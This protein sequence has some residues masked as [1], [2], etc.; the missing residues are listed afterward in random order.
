MVELNKENFEE[1]IT[2]HKGIAC[3]DFWSEK[4]EPCMALMPEVV[5]FAEKNASLAKFAKLDTAGNKRLSIAQKVMGV[6]TIVL[7]KDGERVQV[8]DKE[9]I[10]FGNIQAKLEELQG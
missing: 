6:P 2:N 7:Y 4:C 1:E 5:A 10:D 3:V 8:Y 9:S